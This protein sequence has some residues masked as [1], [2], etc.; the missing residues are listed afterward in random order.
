MRFFQMAGDGVQVAP[1]GTVRLVPSSE[2]PRPAQPLT[3]IQ[4]SFSICR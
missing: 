1:L 3:L 2:P 4:F